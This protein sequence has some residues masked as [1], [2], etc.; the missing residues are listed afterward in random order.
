MIQGELVGL[1]FGGLCA[2]LLAMPVNGGLAARYQSALL[3]EK[4]NI[5]T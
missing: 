5:L 2:V 1:G 3:P 4:G